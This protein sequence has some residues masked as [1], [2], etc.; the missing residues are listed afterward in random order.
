MGKVKVLGWGDIPCFKT[1]ENRVDE[2]YATGFDGMVVDLTF[3]NLDVDGWNSA[4]SIA[5]NFWG[6]RVIPWSGMKPLWYG[7][8]SIPAG[9]MSHNFLRCNTTPGTDGDWFDSVMTNIHNN[10]V[11]L[12][13]LA[14]ASRCKGIV[15]DCE[16]YTYNSGAVWNYFYQPNKGSHNFAAYQAK[17][18]EFAYALG[19]AMWAEFPDINFMVADGYY[20]ESDDTGHIPSEKAY[21]LYPSFL[22]GLFD[23]TRYYPCVRITTMNERTYILKADYWFAAAA[24]SSG[25]SASAEWAKHS[26]IAL[27]TNVVSAPFDNVNTAGNFFT[28]SVLQATADISSRRTDKYIWLY[29]GGYGWV[30]NPG[31][32]KLSLDYKDCIHNIKALIP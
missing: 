12:A 2:F 3:S 10:F 6:S 28:P 21:G 7:Y 16:T 24:S 32:D 5:S 30:R 22:N 19:L 27:A 25:G 29:T 23:S 20:L 18:Y 11:A 31:T 13:A 1:L 8:N 15:F 9:A 14:K 4:D 17:V 26:N